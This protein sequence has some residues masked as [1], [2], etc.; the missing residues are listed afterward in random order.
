[1][2]QRIVYIDN[3]KALAI[4]T[5][6]IGHVFYFTW[7]KYNDN[8]WNNFISV[9][10]MP[11]FFFLSGMFAKEGLSLKHIG[12]K[13]KQLLIPTATIG[14]T[15][16]YFNNGIHDYLFGGGTFWLLVFAYLVYYVY[17]LLCQMPNSKA[18]F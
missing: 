13:A 11:L 5:V 16:A 2:K 12:R 14:G 8:V 15:Y 6:V 17:F 1:M 18:F 10:N 7:N 4:F 9:Y 3:L